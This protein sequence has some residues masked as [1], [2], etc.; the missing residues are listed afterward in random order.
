LSS[1]GTLH[2]RSAPKAKRS[3]SAATRLFH[4]EL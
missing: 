3:F 1:E 2:K 4:Y